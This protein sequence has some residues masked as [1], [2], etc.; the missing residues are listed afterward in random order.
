ML[1]RSANRYV[2]VAKDASDAPQEVVDA[3]EKATIGEPQMVESEQYL[4]VF[5]KQDMHKDPMYF[6]QERNA[7]LGELKSEDYEAMIKAYAESLT[8]EYNDAALSKY[9]P[10]KIKLK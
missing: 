5:A 8:I 4:V 2:L 7:L 10:K 9:V 6:E 1:F 3:M